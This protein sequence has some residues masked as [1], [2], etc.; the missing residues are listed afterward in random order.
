MFDR[1]ALV[2]GNVAAVTSVAVLLAWAA[3]LYPPWT[4]VVF[5]IGVAVILGVWVSQRASEVF[6]EQRR[7][8]DRAEEEKASQTAL[9]AELRRQIDQ[10]H[11]RGVEINERS[12]RRIGADLHDGPA[13]LLGLV[14]LKL[15]E[16][17]PHLAD[18]TDASA[19]LDTLEL[20]R[21]ATA[22]AMSEI[23]NTARGLVLPDIEQVPLASALDLAAKSHG[24]RTRMLVRTEIGTLP[25]HVPLPVTISLFRFAQEGLNNAFRHAGGRGQALSAHQAGQRIIVEVADAGDGF[26]PL[27]LEPR[28]DRMGLVALRQ[29]LESLGGTLEIRSAPGQGTRLVASFP[30]ALSG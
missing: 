13:Q 2:A 29:R 1:D 3:G 24:Q 7:L 25:Q 17:V 28:K 11:R 9:V 12:L 14:L 10:A 18:R 19:P 8:L 27:K 22:E 20:I 5:L 21:R 6:S 30:T 15:D 26:D 4:A 23:R 16:L